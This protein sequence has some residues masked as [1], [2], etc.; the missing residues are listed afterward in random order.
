[1]VI[2]LVDDEQTS[3]H[4]MAKF[5]QKFG[6]VVIEADNAVE[7]LGIL[8]TR[9]V[10]LL[11]TDIRMP[12]MSGIDLLRRMRGLPGKER[13]PA[14]VFTAFGDM[15]SAIDA[16]RLGARDYLFKPVDVKEL[17]SV[18]NR[19]EDASSFS[20]EDK[21][22]DCFADNSHQ[23]KGDFFNI[24]GI[25]TVGV[26]SQKMKQVFNQ[27][28]LLHNEP[29]IPV[30]IRGETGTGKELVARFIHYGPENTSRP[31]VDVNC[32]ALPA[33]LFESELFGYEA[34]AFT[35]GVP[36]GRPGK[37]D[38]AEGGSLFLDEITEIPF[39]LQ[40]KLLRAIQEKEFFRVGGL[41]KVKCNVRIICATNV[42]VEELVEKQE[43]RRDLYYRLNM[44]SIIIPPLRERKEDIIPLAYMF[45]E[46][47]CSDRNKRFKTISRQTEEM[48]LSYTWPGNVRELRNVI[49]RAV[50]LWDDRSLKPEHLNLPINYNYPIETHDNNNLLDFK[51]SDMILPKEGLPLEKL[52]DSIIAKALEM[53]KGNKTKTA[54]Y[55]GIS[56]RSL[57]Y[58]LKQIMKPYN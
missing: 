20:E 5:L 32:S 58:R 33:T 34:G 9:Q 2:M 12:G 26:F 30:L 22:S 13:T 8:Q 52:I 45:M 10:G 55:L 54:R 29:D 31:F 14:V 44:G 19:I 51:V 15:Q 25:G 42:I 24:Q 27:A 37:F 3:R 47:F 40:A 50:L 39:N 49:A 21:L 53:H 38:L 48:L 41:K 4:F 11:L 46:E 18:I 7:A 23:G 57:S 43:F 17:I 16:L 6:H 56:V 36:G 35:G 28:R 1:M